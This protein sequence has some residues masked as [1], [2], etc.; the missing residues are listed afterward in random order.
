MKTNK[1][2]VVGTSFAASLLAAGLLVA[3]AMA[4][5]GVYQGQSLQGYFSFSWTKSHAEGTA[6]NGFVQVEAKQDGAVAVS[7]PG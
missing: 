4:A 6:P 3:P 7:R 5:Y 2:I 1:K